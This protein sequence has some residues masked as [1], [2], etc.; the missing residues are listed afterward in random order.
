MRVVLP[1]IPDKGKFLPK[2]WAAA[3]PWTQRIIVDALE[4]GPKVDV[5]ALDLG[6]QRE[7]GHADVAVCVAALG[8]HFSVHVA[9]KLHPDCD[10]GVRS[11]LQ[12]VQSHA[13]AITNKFPTFDEATQA[14]YFSSLIFA[15]PLPTFKKLRLAQKAGRNLPIFMLV[16]GYWVCAYFILSC[17][18]LPTSTGPLVTAAVGPHRVHLSQQGSVCTVAHRRC[19]RRRNMQ[20]PRQPNAPLSL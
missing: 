6:P 7:L 5:E 18:N 10:K 4:M 20:R 13:K 1:W 9:S 12:S 16:C 11:V 14:L 2:A 15:S 17:L 19:S 8:T 3:S